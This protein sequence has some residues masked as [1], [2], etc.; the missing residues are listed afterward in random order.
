MSIFVLLFDKNK[1]I[2]LMPIESLLAIGYIHP[3][4]VHSIAKEKLMASAPKFKAKMQ[5]AAL[6]ALLNQ[7]LANAI[8]VKLAAKQAHWNV[9]GENFIALHELFDQVA[10]EV[11]G[12]ADML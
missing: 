12:Y 10:T 11:D 7:S 6:I 5:P 2:N 1:L 3:A 9:K 8:D 4:H